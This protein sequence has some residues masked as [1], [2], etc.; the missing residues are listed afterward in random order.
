[1]E[2]IVKKGRRRTISIEIKNGDV[3]VHVPAA[4]DASSALRR[5]VDE[6]VELKRV[7]IEK[8]LLECRMSEDILFAAFCDGRALY[9]HGRSIG[10]IETER[11][12]RIKYENGNFYIPA[13]FTG[14]ARKNAVSSWYKKYAANE[15]S[16][17]LDRISAATG[18]SYSSF[19]LTSAKGKWGSCSDKREIMLNYRLVALSDRLVDYVIVHELCHTT[20]LNHSVKFWRTVE[21]IIPDYKLRRQ[22]L[23]VYRPLM[24]MI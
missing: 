15:L 13:A 8:K 20:E 24:L 7:W 3:I 11:G 19:S 12:R 22:E 6:F 18:L 16:A 23:K 21:K 10:I 5:S 9:L 14:N 17:R 1:M 4:Y 2:Y